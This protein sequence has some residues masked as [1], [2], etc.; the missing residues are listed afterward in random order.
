MPAVRIVM[1]VLMLAFAAAAQSVSIQKDG[2][3]Y[4]VAGW[5]PGSEDPPDGWSSIFALYA[6]EGDVPPMLGTYS[7]EDEVL[8]FRPRYPPTPGVRIRAVFRMPDGPPLEAVFQTAKAN[9]PPS[10]YVEHVY[11][12]TDVLPDNQLKLYIQFSAPMSRGEAWKRIHLLDE[13]GSPVEL[14]FVEIDQELWSPENRRLTVLFDPGRIK[15]GLLP[16][17]EVGPPLIEGRQYTLVI[18]SDWRDARGVPLKE[19]FRKQFRVA[20]SDRVPPDVSNWRLIVPEAHTADA[21]VVRFPEPL[22][23]ALLQ[24]VFDISGPAGP[25]A[26]SVAVERD[27]TEWRFIPA[28]PWRPGEYQLLVDTVLEDLAGN[29]IGRPFDVDLNEFNQGMERVIPKTVSLWFW[30][31]EK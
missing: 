9:A 18:D 6:G 12:S 21:V 2:A 14:P 26:G 16:H 7:V 20:P 4:K 10:T 23:W 24:R 30:V 15:R 22:D 19:G 1:A 27:E 28:E 8:V 11:P 25:V 17:E 13:T 31:G 3:G 29:H 5:N